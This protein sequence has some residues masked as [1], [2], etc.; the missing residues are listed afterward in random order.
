MMPDAAP[1]D[2]Q[3]ILQVPGD[4]S[5]GSL[6]RVLDELDRARID[7]EHLS[8]HSPDL[9]DVFFAVTGHATTEP[10]GHQEQEALQR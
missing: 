8:I 3:L 7:V 5:V 9:D 6:R 4:G 10:A 1:D 2:E